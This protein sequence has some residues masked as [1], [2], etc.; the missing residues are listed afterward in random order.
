MVS[1]FLDSL[2]SS[3]YEFSNWSNSSLKPVSKISFMEILRFWVLILLKVILSSIMR[4]ASDSAM[5]DSSHVIHLID[6]DFQLLAAW[7]LI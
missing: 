1:I 3:D 7:L 5:K 6:H 2:R 4:V